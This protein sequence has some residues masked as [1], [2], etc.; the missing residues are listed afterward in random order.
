MMSKLSANLGFLWPEL[1][2]PRR[3]EAAARAGFRAVELHWPYDTP[4]QVV[5]DVCAEHG[6][7]LLG[8]NT[9]AG[10][11]VNGEFG[12]GALP[13]RETDFAEAFDRSVDYCL[14]SGAPAIHVMAGVVRDEEHE[15]V[16]DTLVRNLAGAAAKAQEHG[17][18]LLL[19]PIN[20]RDKPGYFYATTGEAA[21]VIA[22]VGA[23]NI[24]PM[25]DV[26]HV[27]ISEGDVLR[28]FER[29]LPVIGHVQIAAVPSR[30]EPDEGEIAYDRVLAA[31][32]ASGYD[33]WIGCEY[34]PRG[35]TDQGLA[36]M[37]AL[38]IDP[39]P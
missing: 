12:L 30:A 36:W 22:D 1:P 35:Q 20:H 37:R 19:E 32:E 33:G 25:F 39:R 3:I 29:M 21:S 18:T 26:Y 7:T 14:T 11:T 6:V 34:K 10:D 8:L 27:A 4:A 16:R 17:L 15:R 5:R 13:S 9:P 28:R 24:K 31:I 23:G 2:L 38:G